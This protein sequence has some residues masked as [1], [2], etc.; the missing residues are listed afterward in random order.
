MI[1][2]VPEGG[3]EPTTLSLEG[4]C[5]STEL[6]GRSKS[7]WFPICFARNFTINLKQK[8]KKIFKIKK[9][10]AEKIFR[11]EFTLVVN[12]REKFF[13]TLKFED[14]QNFYLQK[15]SPQNLGMYLLSHVKPRSTID[16]TELNYCVR[17][18]N[19]CTLRA[20]HTKIL[21]RNN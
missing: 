15:I 18:G 3:I 6:P 20:I 9:F 5:S 4:F 1:R 17:N 8:G 7:V 10:K 21:K 13:I 16:A 11:W 2:V 12:D 14:F 19:R